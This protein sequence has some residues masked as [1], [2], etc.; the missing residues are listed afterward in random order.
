MK[1]N[2]LLDWSEVIALVQSAQ[3]PIDFSSVDEASVAKAI[4]EGDAAAH[5]PPPHRDVVAPALSVPMA[6]AADADPFAQ[7]L[8]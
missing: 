7:R 3:E 2:E 4:A 6:E 1:C 8:S 5:L